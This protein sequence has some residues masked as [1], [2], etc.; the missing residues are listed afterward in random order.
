MSS[1]ERVV[2]IHDKRRVIAETL[3][4]VNLGAHGACAELRRGDLVIEPPADILGPGLAAVLPPG[5]TGVGGLGMEAAI[6]IHPALFAQK[7]AEP[8]TLFGQKA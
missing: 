3:F 4:L 1:H 8:G 7:A 2:V 6:G 5:V